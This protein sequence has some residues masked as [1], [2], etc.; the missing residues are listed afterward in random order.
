MSE[1]DNDGGKTPPEPKPAPLKFDTP[2]Y[3]II[4]KGEDQSGLETRNIKPGERK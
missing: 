3:D 4:E 1:H 2:V